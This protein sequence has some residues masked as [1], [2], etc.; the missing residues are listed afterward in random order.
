M[1]VLQGLSAPIRRRFSL[2][3][4]SPVSRRKARAYGITVIP[5]FLQASPLKPSETRVTRIFAL[6]RD[7]RCISPST[8]TLGRDRT[9]LVAALY[10]LYFLGMPKS[11]ARAYMDGMTTASKT[12]CWLVAC[13]V[14]SNTT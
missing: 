13:A 7:K 6:M 3:R 12:H 10:R 1:T 9:S 4:A 14:T 2:L 5:I 8:S 11:E